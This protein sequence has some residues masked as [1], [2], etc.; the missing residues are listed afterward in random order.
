L[1]EEALILEMHQKNTKIN[2]FDDV[3]SIWKSS[4]ILVYKEIINKV[5][6]NSAIIKYISNI[7]HN[8][9]NNKD[10]FL[11]ASPRASISLLKGSRAIA[12]INGRD[13]VIPEDVQEIVEAVLAHRIMITAEKEME[14]SSAEEVI[15]NVVKSVEI[16]R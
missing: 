8:T 3:N 13:F 10:V 2:Q 9:R 5:N 16:P 4:D 7:V 15:Q 1:E 11:G 12:A 14:G 6:V